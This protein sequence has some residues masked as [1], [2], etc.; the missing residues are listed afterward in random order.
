MMTTMDHAYRR[1]QAVAIEAVRVAARLCR[2]VRASMAPDVIAKKDKSPVTVA[3][4][5]SQA[6]ICRALADAFPLD[7]VIA[8]EDSSELRLAG[9]AP[10]LD[11][12]VTHVSATGGP[13]F[14]GAVPPVSREDVCRWVDHGGTSTYCER[15]WT[16]DPID[17]TKGFLR[18]HQYAVALALI[19]NGEVAVAALACPGLPA[20]TGLESIHGTIFSAVRGHGAFICEAESSGG[21][22]RSPARATVSSRD[23]PAF[24]Q[25][26]ESVESGHSAQG[27][28]AAVTAALG[29]RR[30]PLRMDSQA[31]YAVVARGEAD[32]YL[33]LPTH[34]DYRERIWDHAAGALIVAEAGG[35]VTD[36]RGRPLEFNHGRELAANRGV[37]VSNGRIHDRVIKAIER[38]GIS[39][40]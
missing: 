7:P 16:L 12:V 31:K 15:F 38:L 26:C 21:V 18:G 17:G 27:E 34:V 24:L 20:R 11:Q 37:I 8:E 13:A 40:D 30:P 33:R 22:V 2:A 32:L 35:A 4:F 28:S 29:I 1:E 9:N 5:G 3:D 23:D 36:I 25:F 10:V 19:V 14:L 6:L 39:P